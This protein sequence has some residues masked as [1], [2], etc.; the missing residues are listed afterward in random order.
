M[1]RTHL[2][3]SFQARR[4]EDLPMPRQSYGVDFYGVPKGE[5]LVIVDLCTREATLVFMTTR[6]QDKVAR[7]LLTHII[8][9]R[10][11]PTT[12]RSDSAPELVAG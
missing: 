10:G 8:F 12:L 4:L 7:A 3:S 2:S 5:I 9:S 11:V 6:S 1:R